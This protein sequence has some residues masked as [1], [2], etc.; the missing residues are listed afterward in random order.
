MHGQHRDV[1]T[2]DILGHFD[3]FGRYGPLYFDQEMFVLTIV[4]PICEFSSNNLILQGIV[5]LIMIL[6]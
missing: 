3:Y 5:S 6:N 1:S 4:G 2:Y